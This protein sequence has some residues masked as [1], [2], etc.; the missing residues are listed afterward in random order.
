MLHFLFLWYIINKGCSIWYNLEVMTLHCFLFDGLSELMENNIYETLAECVTVNRG[1]E[2]YKI[3]MLGILK[4]GKAT[5]MRQSD[6]GNC[7]KMRSLNECELFGAASVFGSWKEGS[8]SI[9]ADGVC[10]VVYISEVNFKNI[11]ASYP[12]VAINYIEYLSDKIR[13]LNRKIDTFSAKSTEQKLYE[14]LLSQADAKNQV[15]LKFGMSELARRLN[16]G[17]TSLYRDIASL[18]ESGLIIR[19]GQNFIIK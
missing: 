3:G 9:I 7:V 11:L 12:A 14:F 8:S 4:S 15:K 6:T 10:E 1:G 16:V 19:E 2:L 5:I 17:R 13:F 18:E